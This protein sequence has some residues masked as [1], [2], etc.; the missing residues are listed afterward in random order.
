M[1]KGA[2]IVGLSIRTDSRAR[3]TNNPF[4]PTFKR[5]SGSFFTGTSYAANV[6]KELAAIGERPTFEAK[7]RQWGQE[8]VPSRVA[9]HNGKLY[10]VTRTTR[11][12][13]NNVKKKVSF[14]TAE[15]KEIPF[16]EI[17]PFLKE[18]PFSARQVAAGLDHPESHVEQRDICFD[19]IIKARLR[20]KTYLVIP[21]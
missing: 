17:A 9:E 13:R 11:K 21:D 8:V 3:K 2:E 19:S 7:P 4:G 16:E 15:G 10:L 14:E 1:R 12:I 6:N 5:S 18:K 20:G